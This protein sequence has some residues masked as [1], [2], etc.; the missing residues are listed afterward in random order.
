M[1]MGLVILTLGAIAANG[2]PLGGRNFGAGRG[3]RA[4]HG[5]GGGHVILAVILL[6][7]GVA[8]ATGGDGQERVLLFNTRGLAVSMAASFAMYFA[9]AAQLKLAFILTQIQEK[10]IDAGV[11]LELICNGRQA[12]FLIRWFRQK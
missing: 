12:K 5:R 8:D 10:G 3:G 7:F 6:W 11:L 4:G 2:R 9:Q 1:G